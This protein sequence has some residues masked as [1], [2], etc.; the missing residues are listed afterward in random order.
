MDFL[1]VRVVFQPVYGY[2]SKFTQIG[3]WDSLGFSVCVLLLFGNGI[4]NTEIKSQ[5]KPY[6]CKKFFVVCFWS[7]CK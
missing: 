3:I 7:I 6:V 4:D 1:F 5:L 2:H